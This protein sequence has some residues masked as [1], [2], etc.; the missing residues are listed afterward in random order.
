MHYKIGE[1][2]TLSG[3]SVKALR[4][5]DQIQLLQPACV[6]PRTRYRLYAPE[7]IRQVDAILA[8][9]ELGAS[10]ED[11]RDVVSRGATGTTR[12]RRLLIKLRARAQ[13]SIEVANKSLTWIDAALGDSDEEN[14]CASV[15]LKQRPPMR[16]AS[17][18]ATLGRYSEITSL[19]RELLCAI[20]P[21]FTGHSQGVLWHRCEDSG[22]IEA[23][24]FV[25]VNGRAPP[26]TVYE[27]KDLPSATVAST[28]CEYED[29]AAERA[30]ESIARW[31]SAHE[32][33]LAGPK[34]EIYVGKILEIQFP[35]K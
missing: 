2:A 15:V 26:S 14:H 7:Q 4:F 29:H 19:E 32:Y 13:K 30:Y 8:L 35:V 12:R 18:R 9:K 6:D 10:L 23:E 17:V 28:V 1:F 31:L 22:A 33:R 16:V 11:I 27:L 20:Y 21:Q 3:L 34:R 5:Y 24:P 25:Q